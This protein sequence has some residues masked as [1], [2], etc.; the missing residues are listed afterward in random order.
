MGVSLAGCN[1][2]DDILDTLV[3]FRTQSNTIEDVQEI[4]N[5]DCIGKNGTSH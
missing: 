5:S 3:H 2:I 1:D 4:P